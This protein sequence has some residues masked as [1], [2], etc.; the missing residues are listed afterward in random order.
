MK[1]GARILFTI[2]N[3]VPFGEDN[4]S[5]YITGDGPAD[6]AR[7]RL[8]RPGYKP[9]RVILPDNAWELGYTSFFAGYELS[10]CA[11]SRRVSTEGGQKSR[12]E[13]KLPAKA[14]LVYSLH[15]DVFRGEWQNG[16]RIMFR[17]RYI[18]DLDKFDNTLYGRKDLAWIRE[19]YIIVLQMAWDRDFYDRFTGK[20][21]Y[22][23][24]IKRD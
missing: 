8:F 3:I 12:Y 16:L 14:K 11:L 5:V 13:T 15:A 19:S 6:L 17:D 22:P 4:G 7:A 21:T 2:S 9:V 23:D 20:Y 18:Y 1:T 24:V 10:V